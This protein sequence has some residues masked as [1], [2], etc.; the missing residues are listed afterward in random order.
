MA[1]SNLKIRFDTAALLVKTLNKTS[2]KTSD[3]EDLLYLYGMYKQA[4]I[5][6]CNI[7]EPSLMSLKAHAKWE[8][9]KQKKDIETNVAMVFYIARTDEIFNKLQS[10]IH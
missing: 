9:W 1:E 8:S 6:N 3:K 4:T 5:G 10:N 7:A 2:D